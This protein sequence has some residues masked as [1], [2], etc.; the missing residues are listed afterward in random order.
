M[1]VVVVLSSLEREWHAEPRARPVS[2]ADAASDVCAVCACARQSAER[3]CSGGDDDDDCVTSSLRRWWSNGGAVR[4]LLP[5]KLCIRIVIIV[6]VRRVSVPG[7]K[8]VR[9]R[10][11]CA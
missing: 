6:T 3:I 7:L 5:A 2:V 8:R 10:A 1:A 9:V 4:Q 11:G